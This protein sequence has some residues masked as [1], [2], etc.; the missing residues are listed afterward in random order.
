MTINREIENYK[1]DHSKF[2]G[3]IY[4]F[5]FDTEHNQSKHIAERIAADI[6]FDNMCKRLSE[7]NRKQKKGNKQK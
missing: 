2:G 3:L 5:D 4:S 1:I 7:N 6:K